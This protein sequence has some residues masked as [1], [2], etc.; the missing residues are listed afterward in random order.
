MKSC[1]ELS[2][3]FY[4]CILAWLLWQPRPTKAYSFP[5]IYLLVDLLPILKSDASLLTSCSRHT[6]LWLSATR[7]LILKSRHLKGGPQPL[8]EQQANREEDVCRRGRAG[9]CS[10]NC[11]RE[12]GPVCWVRMTTTETVAKQRCRCSFTLESKTDSLFYHGIR[13]NCSQK[14]EMWPWKA[15][16]EPF[17]FSFFFFW[18]L[19]HETLFIDL[20]PSFRALTDNKS[21]AHIYIGDLLCKRHCSSCDEI[22]ET[23]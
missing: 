8:A 20:V 13:F 12:T 6:Y 17:S 7:N 19:G 1:L 11:T 3:V 22:V 10:C 2:R 14:M 15:A 18:I 5:F 23:F 21:T 4:C 9:S 16:S